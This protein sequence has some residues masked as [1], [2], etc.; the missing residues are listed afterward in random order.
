MRCKGVIPTPPPPRP[1][2]ARIRARDG[3][4]LRTLHGLPDSRTRRSNK[5]GMTFSPGSPA[6]LP[7]VQSSPLVIPWRVTLNHR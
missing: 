3:A 6:P 2:A 7:V 4:A 5:A 1:C